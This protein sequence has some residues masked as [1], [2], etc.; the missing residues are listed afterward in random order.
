MVVLAYRMVKAL[1]AVHR[2]REAEQ[3]RRRIHLLAE[4]V[5]KTTAV[6]L[7][8]GAVVAVVEQDQLVRRHRPLAVMAVRAERHQ[9]LVQALRMQA[10]AEA[11]VAQ[12]VHRVTLRLLAAMG[13]LVAVELVQHQHGTGR[14]VRLQTEQMDPQT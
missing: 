9:L 14:T 2:E 11:A 12:V 13:G 6:V 10:A 5:Q 1:M 3:G 4:L 8:T 7:L